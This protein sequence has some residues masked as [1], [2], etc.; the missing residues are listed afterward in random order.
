MGDRWFY[1]MGFGSEPQAF[2]ADRVALGSTDG[3]SGREPFGPVFVIEAVPN[4]TSKQRELVS[5]LPDTPRRVRSE[6]RRGLPPGRTRLNRLSVALPVALD[7]SGPVDDSNIPEDLGHPFDVLPETL[8]ASVRVDRTDR[9][10]VSFETV[11][12]SVEIRDSAVELAGPEVHTGPSD[13]PGERSIEV[14]GEG[15]DPSGFTMH[16]VFPQPQLLSHSPSRE[17]APPADCRGAQR[18][19]A[20]GGPDHLD[21]HVEQP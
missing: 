3:P 13:P 1:K 19:D 7:R 6:D 4:R 12:R 2:V 5:Q 11:D 16:P 15:S 14:R 9:S 17:P 8:S 21:D 10:P 18:D 20:C